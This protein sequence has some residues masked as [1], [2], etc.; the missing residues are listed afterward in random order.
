M[1]EDKPRRIFFRALIHTIR[2]TG[3]NVCEGQLFASK[4]KFWPN[5][6]MGYA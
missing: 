2:L 3:H 6:V 4:L 1:I 5:Q